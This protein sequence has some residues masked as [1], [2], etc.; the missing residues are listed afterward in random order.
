VVA[1]ALP[2]ISA[3]DLALI[4]QTFD[5]IFSKVAFVVTFMAGFTVAT[6]VVV[7]AGAILSGRFQRIRETVLLR[8]LGATRRQLRQIQLVE[9]VV[10][11]VLATVTGGGLAVLANALRAKFVFKTAMVLP[12]W[13]LA[14][15]V[16]AA[17]AVTLVTGLLA[18]RGIVDHPPLEVLR[19][20][21]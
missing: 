19:A 15:S 11:G 3:I 2:G 14:G 18:N 16:A 4:L 20:E 10:L 7:L 8:T 6:G 12:G 17:V 13:A 9:Y 21:T 1:Q 5:G